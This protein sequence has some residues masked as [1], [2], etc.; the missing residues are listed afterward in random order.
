MFICLKE[1]NL[2]NIGYGHMSEGTEPNQ[3]RLWLHMSEGTG[4]NQHRLWSHMSEGAE[5]NQHRLW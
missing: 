3:H 2:I 5:P 1:Q 4:P